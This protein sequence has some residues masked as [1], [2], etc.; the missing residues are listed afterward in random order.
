MVDRRGHA[1]L[2]PA[3]SEPV[4]R[5]QVEAALQRLAKLIAANTTADGALENRVI[6][7]EDAPASYTAENARD[8]IGAALVAGTDISITVN[9]PANTITIASTASAGAPTGA[10]YLCLA[11]HASL[12]AERVFVPSTGLSAVDGGANGN[13]TLS[14]T[15]TQYTD[16]MAQDAVAAMWVDGTGID[17]AYVDGTPTFTVSVD[18]SEIARWETVREIDFNGWPATDFAAGG[19][20]TYSLNDGSGALTWLADATANA[21]AAGATTA[22]CGFFRKNAADV[23]DDGASGLRIAHDTGTST[24]L[25]SSTTPGGG[26]GPPRLSVLLTDLVSDYSPTEEYRFEIHITRLADRGTAP[27]NAGI[28]ISVGCPTNVPT[29]A[30]AARLGSAAMQR[31][32]A[33]EGAPTVNTSTGSAMKVTDSAYAFTNGAAGSTRNDVLAVAIRPG[34]IVTAYVAGP[35]SGGW[36]AETAYRCC[37]TGLTGTLSTTAAIDMMARGTYVTIAADSR[38]SAVGC[39]D[40]MVRRMRVLRRVR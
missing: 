7:L 6:D 16:E 5:Q 3:A 23:G 8:D 21:N 24:S 20:T 17:S 29:G 12:S 1:F 32:G 27:I 19:D 14:C 30:S 26:S 39:V 36:P 2:D 31:N 10:Q 35:Y 34:N 15:I 38:T 25:S 4:H 28:H 22:N 9:D 18:I 40:F 33:N 11:T 13:Y 37:G